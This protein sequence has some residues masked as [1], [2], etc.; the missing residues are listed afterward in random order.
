MKVP[1]TLDM[2]DR[3]GAFAEIGEARQAHGV[4]REALRHDVELGRLHQH[5]ADREEAGQHRHDADPLRQ[6]G[7]PEGE[8]LDAGRE[9]EPDR[10]EQHAEGA[11]DEVADAA[12]A[13]DGAEHRQAEQREREI[14]RRAEIVGRAREERRRDDHHHDAR[15][16]R[17][18]RSRPSTCRA[19][20]RPRP[21]S[22]SG[23]RHRRWRR[24]RGR[25]AC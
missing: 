17:R 24:R 3:L 14:F 2:R 9:I 8:A 5:L 7:Q 6:L 13:A 20:A 1:S 19:R 22:P 16:C 18:W 15:R 25:R 21:S 12:L 4:E 10:R 23:S 11:G